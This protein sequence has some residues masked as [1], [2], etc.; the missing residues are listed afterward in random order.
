MGSAL[1]ALAA[2]NEHHS[3]L[4]NSLNPQRLEP[5]PT[6]SLAASVLKDVQDIVLI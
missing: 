2:P 1:E 5:W 6:N 3:S 4:Q